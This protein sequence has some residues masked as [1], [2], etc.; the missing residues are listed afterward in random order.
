M[1]KDIVPRK[2]VIDVNEQ[3]VFQDALLVYQKQDENGELSV[4]YNTISIK[5]TINVPV[6][7]GMLKKMIDFAKEQEGI[8]A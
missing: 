5:S 8:S 6:I 1:I 3:G 7:N 4:K 2:I